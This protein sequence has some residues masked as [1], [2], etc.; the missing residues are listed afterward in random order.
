MINARLGIGTFAVLSPSREQQSC[1]GS[2]DL[3]GTAFLESL[4]LI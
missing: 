4:G 1:C 3:L 2:W